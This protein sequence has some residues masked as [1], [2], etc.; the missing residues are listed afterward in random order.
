MNGPNNRIGWC[1]YTWNPVTGCLLG[2]R[3]CYARAISKRFGRSFY[4]SFY[5]ERLDEP[6]KVKKH[7]R[8]FIP[9]MG[10]LCGPWVPW[11][12][13][14]AVIETME[15]T[16][17]HTFQV[18]TKFPDVASNIASWPKNVWLGASVDE[19]HDGVYDIMDEL[20]QSCCDTVFVSFE[21]VLSGFPEWIHEWLNTKR[22]DWM[23]LGALTRNG[24]TVAFEKGG[25]RREWVDQLLEA[26]LRHSI[27]IYM[28]ENLRPIFPGEPFLQQWPEDE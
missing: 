18:L 3:Y 20:S 23:I 28:K 11:E 6:K 17:W 2:C 21:P 4:P 12:W 8:I 22:I 10:E 19:F 1:D 5:P 25:T 14:K 26:G 15:A 27:P 24:R 7:S 13:Q 16:P 9:S